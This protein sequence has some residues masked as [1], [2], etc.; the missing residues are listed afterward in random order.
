[1]WSTWLYFDGYL[2]TRW[3]II[4]DHGDT[5]DIFGEPGAP[6]RHVPRTNGIRVCIGS[7]QLIEA[8]TDR[9][10]AARGRLC[11]LPSWIRVSEGGGSGE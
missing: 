10:A 3:C 5:I 11:Q 1:M 7:T 4:P 2:A 8:A 9:M 6:I